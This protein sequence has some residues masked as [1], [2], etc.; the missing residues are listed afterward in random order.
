MAAHI[1]QL[2][3]IAIPVFFRHGSHSASVKLADMHPQ[4]DERLLQ[5]IGQVTSLARTL[6]DI[7]LMISPR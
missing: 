6:S 4:A 2:M 1:I 5:P 7:L 3:I